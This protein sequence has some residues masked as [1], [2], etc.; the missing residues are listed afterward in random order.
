MNRDRYAALI[1]TLP[2]TLTDQE[3]NVRYATN[4]S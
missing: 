2:S 4:D 1:K 3:C